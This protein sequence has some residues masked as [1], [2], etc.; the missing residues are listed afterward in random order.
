MKQIAVL[1]RSIIQFLLLNLF[2]TKRRFDYLM[3]TLFVLIGS[4]NVTQAQIIQ[5]FDFNAPSNVHN[6]GIG[7]YDKPG[8]GSYHARTNGGSATFNAASPDC[9]GYTKGACT[10]SC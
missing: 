3:A 5:V 9:F 6:V 2:S 7:G 1:K 8:V 4:T 10:S